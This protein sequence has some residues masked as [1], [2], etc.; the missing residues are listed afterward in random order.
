MIGLILKRQ[1][2]RVRDLADLVNDERQ[3]LR[4][5]RF[6]GYKR[7]QQ[8][9]NSDSVLLASFIGGFVTGR[10]GKKLLRPLRAIPVISIIKKLR[11]YLPLGL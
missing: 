5:M 9:F 6:V 1:Q 8:M 7:L 10:H 2:R 11:P 3:L 4:N